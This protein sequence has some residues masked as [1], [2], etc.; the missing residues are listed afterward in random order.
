MIRVQTRLL[1]LLI[2]LSGLFLGGLLIIRHM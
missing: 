1:L 2:T